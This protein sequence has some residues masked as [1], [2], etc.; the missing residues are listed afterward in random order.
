M[1]SILHSHDRFFLSTD[2]YYFMYRPDNN[3]RTIK[4]ATLYSSSTHN[5]IDDVRVSAG[6]GLPEKTHH[7][8]INHFESNL[9]L[10][11][12]DLRCL[13]W[14]QPFGTLMRYGK[15]ETRNRPTLVRG[16]VLIY[17]SKKGY[18]DWEFKA[19]AGTRQ[20]MRARSAF[21][22]DTTRYQHGYAIA[23]GTLLNSYPM[24]KKHEDETF[25]EFQGEGRLHCWKFTDVKKIEPF[26]FDIWSP[27]KKKRISAGSQGWG[28]VPEELKS[29]IK[30]I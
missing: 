24:L 15:V 16:Q 8:I 28:F 25:V 20:Y 10:W 12:K 11:L 27:E 14:K 17:T 9:T 30:F 22:G 2:G 7:D 1:S 19:I 26:K 5:R 29:K 18:D 3:D 6:W 13:A 21:I 23:V 4:R